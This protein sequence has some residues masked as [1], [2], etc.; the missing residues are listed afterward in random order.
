MFHCVPPEVIHFLALVWHVH[1]LH[2]GYSPER[3]FLKEEATLKG[4]SLGTFACTLR[5]TGQIQ[6]TRSSLLMHMVRGSG[7]NR[8]TAANRRPR[9]RKSEPEKAIRSAWLWPNP[10]VL[11]DTFGRSLAHRDTTI[12][13]ARNESSTN[14][15]RRQQ[16]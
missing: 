13:P 4:L 6:L 11:T 16:K 1:Y 15:K 12:D 5:R 8:I 10:V 14:A 2:I 9:R 3:L 7:D